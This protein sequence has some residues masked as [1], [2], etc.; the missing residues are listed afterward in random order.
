MGIKTDSR[1]QKRISKRQENQAA[2]DLGGRT[3]AN[4]GA[5]RLGGGADVRV[6]GSAR[7]ECKFTSKSFYVLTYDDL[8]KLRVQA[9]KSLETP[10]FQI[11]FQ[12]NLG[13]FDKYAVIPLLSLHADLTA[14][15]DFEKL[16]VE[17]KSIRIH[18]SYLQANLG[19]ARHLI[20]FGR[21][22]R[23]FEILTWD[24]FLERWEVDA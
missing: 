20:S 7:I 21:R 2:A 16:A 3:Q 12:D 15:K 1:R 4:S 8:E 14:F 19:G 17:G 10:V 5:T 22:P 13:R 11:A 23:Q 9:V 6:L 18:Q 24:K